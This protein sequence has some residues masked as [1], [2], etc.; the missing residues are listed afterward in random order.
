M[1]CLQSE[2][3][4]RLKVD[5]LN[6]LKWTFRTTQGELVVKKLNHSK[7]WTRQGKL[8]ANILEKL[9]EKTFYHNYYFECSSKE[10]K[11]CSRLTLKT[12]E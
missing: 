11:N 7:N 8:D 4:K 1:S 2:R 9:V 5:G 12:L 6:D 3:F 10:F